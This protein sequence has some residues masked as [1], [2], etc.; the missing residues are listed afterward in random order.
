MSRALV[1]CPPA[2]TQAERSSPPRVTGAGAPLTNPGK[3]PAYVPAAHA[4]V[5]IQHHRHPSVQ[6]EQAV[7]VNSRVTPGH[8][9]ITCLRNPLPDCYDWRRICPGGPVLQ[10]SQSALSGAVGEA[11]T[12]D[13]EIVSAVRR[14]IRRWWL[15]VPDLVAA[16]R[17][18]SEQAVRARMQA[19]TDSG[20]SHERRRV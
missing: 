7:L 2:P 17:R 5:N 3:N 14:G 8:A 11:P 19:W 4:T 13:R 16:R 12:I 1:K 20:P 6:V 9:A 15:A 18:P 10:A